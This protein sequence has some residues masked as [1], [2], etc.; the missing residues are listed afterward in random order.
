M[1]KIDIDNIPDF[2]KPYISQIVSDGVIAALEEDLEKICAL[3]LSLSIEKQDYQ[4]A[5]GKW[6]PRQILQHLM[7]T[8]RILCQRALRFARRDTTDLPGFD[9]NAYVDIADVSHRNIVD[10]VEEYRSLRKS[11][12]LFYKSLPSEAHNLE[13]T[14]NG[15]VLSVQNQGYVIAGHALHHRRILQERYLV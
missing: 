3:F 5:E 4:Y 8:E 10:M 2:Y 15:M 6:T 9:H 7:D 1:A 13:G 11:T 12:I 14:A